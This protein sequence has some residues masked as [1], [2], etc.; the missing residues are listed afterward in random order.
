MWSCRASGTASESDRVA[1]VY[2]IADRNQRFREMS[3]YRF[4]PVVVSDDDVVAISS[5]LVVDISYCASKGRTYCVAV[6]Y[7]NVDAMM[8]TSSTN[9]ESRSDMLTYSRIVIVATIDENGVG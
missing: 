7:T 5:A 3:H 1:C 6:F 4:K 9:S 2:G 8:E